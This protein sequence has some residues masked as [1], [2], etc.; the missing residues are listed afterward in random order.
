[1][2]NT[3][4][5]REKLNVKI[6]PASI[7]AEPSLIDTLADERELS[8]RLD[9][10]RSIHSTNLVE[11]VYL[12][13]ITRATPEWIAA[14][15]MPK[16]ETRSKE[17]G[18]RAKAFKKILEQGV[19]IDNLLRIRDMVSLMS[20][21]NVDNNNHDACWEWRGANKG[22]GYGHTRY[23]PAHRRSYEIFKGAI[24]RNMD[25]CHKC[26]N[27]A[28]VNPL[29]LF[30]GTRL[31]NMQDAKRKGRM[32]TGDRLGDRRGEKGSAAKLKW[33]DVNEIRSSAA[34]SSE[35]AVKFG[36]TNTTINT[37]RRNKT[38]CVSK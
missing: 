25:I 14:Q 1:M 27:R 4:L 8:I 28:C 12:L 17:R 13:D 19:G 31:D 10:V 37:I 24:P 9:A 20:K 15:A 36:V 32:A 38:W 2:A 21:V 6:R 3:N 23:G 30:V 34:S 16:G 22:N 18:A 11:A 35:L 26:D 29:H 5:P 33:S 7:T